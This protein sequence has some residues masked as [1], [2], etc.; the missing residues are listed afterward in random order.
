MKWA[1][2]ELLIDWTVQSIRSLKTLILGANT[3]F[4][5]IVC[6]LKP[7]PKKLH[8]RRIWRSLLYS[9]SALKCDDGDWTAGQ[10]LVFLTALWQKPPVQ[11]RLVGFVAVAVETDEQSRVWFT[12]LLCAEMLLLVYSSHEGFLASSLRTFGSPVG[13]R[14]FGSPVGGR[15]LWGWLSHLSENTRL[16]FRH[17]IV[18]TLLLERPV[19]ALVSVLC[20]CVW[21]CVCVSTW[22]G[23]FCCSWIVSGSSD[24]SRCGGWLQRENSWACCPLRW[25]TRWDTHLIIRMSHL[26]NQNCR[27][28]LEST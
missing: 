3:V 19:G 1:Q 24:G 7:K 27:T 23:W 25:Q 16:W 21:A 17:I 18:I 22:Q 12:V 5:S 6:L 26:K 10:T 28:S 15:T 13:G 2:C 9:L 11:L 14:T 20:V 8:S 4:W